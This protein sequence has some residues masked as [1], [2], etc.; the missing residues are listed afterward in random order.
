[1]RKK[2][3]V[4]IFAL[5][6]MIIIMAPAGIPTKTN[7]VASD[8]ASVP[9]QV[10]LGSVL[11]DEAHTANAS[12][13]WVPG[14]AS[15]FGWMLT[16]NGYSA[17]TNLDQEITPSLL[18]GYD[19]FVLFFPMVALSSNEVSTITS[20]V[21]NGG[22]VLLAGTQREINWGFDSS[23]LNPISEEYGVSFNNDV[24]EGDTDSLETH[25]I[26]G[27][28]SQIDLQNDAFGSCSLEVTSPA[29]SIITKDDADIAA[30]AESGSGRVVMVGSTIPFL[31]YRRENAGFGEDHFQFSLNVID[32]L[33]GNPQR[34]AN[35]PE[36]AHI[37]VGSG[38]ALSSAELEE[39][40]MSVGLYH[41]HTTHSDGQDTVEKMVEAGISSSLDFMLLTDHSHGTPVTIGGI[42]GSLAARELV[43]RY[44][45][46]INQF[47]GAELSG[48]K[49]TVGFP[50]TEN[51][52][53][54]NQQVAVD[55]IHAQGGLALFCH[56][57][58]AYNYAE[59]YEAMDALGYDGYE[60][61]N[62]GWMYGSGEG[63]LTHNFI[64]ASDGHRVSF[65][66]QVLNAVFVKDP[67]GPNGEMT[68][69]DFADAILDRRIVILDRV[70]NLIYGEK[71]WVDRF[72]ELR[73][74]AEITVEDAED[75]VEAE[76]ALGH[77]V[78][79]SEMY[80]GLAQ[81]ALD[82]WNPSR[83]IRMASDAASET[84]LGIS[85]DLTGPSV[86][87]P[88]TAFDIVLDVEN[89]NDFAISLNSSLYQITS[90]SV[91][92]INA[93]IDI[94]AESS[95]AATRTG[96]P[97]SEGIV[98]YWLN[99]PSFNTTEPLSPVLFTWNSAIDNVTATAVD[100]DSGYSADVRWHMDAGSRKLVSSVLIAYDDGETSE[101]V[102]MDPSWNWYEYRLGPYSTAT[103]VTVTVTVIDS[104]G[105][106]YEL[107]PRVITI[108]AT[109][110]PAPDLTLVIVGIGAV[111]VI[112]VVILFIKRRQV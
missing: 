70:N 96:T 61:D 76:Q 74:L 37:T 81:A 46:D 63:G 9:A 86:V 85:I 72:V 108:G 110:S 41:D 90:V 67:S 35:V 2:R 50:L 39:Y 34:E 47:I 91:T 42:T 44:G 102:E 5:F 23:R 33:A 68:Q 24:I 21:E 99:I 112:A 43:Q 73:N 53:T 66:G 103:N 111:A 98:S 1:M 30:Y 60:V 64:G 27:D 32:W 89:N 26:T 88:D 87:D 77:D 101:E 3:L 92:P 14:N 82:N 93:V 107:E 106:Q 83:A 79:L 6:V 54:S 51:I 65:V 22:G 15:L 56:P 18:S 58:I 55:E 94:A 31:S 17:T 97:D 84:A 49:H 45:L 25:P 7:D 8:V 95:G 10:P 4:P 57:T 62:G 36:I 59:V 20:F 29:E 40:E 52:F 69:E 12:S 13:L 78:S 16:E 11:F 38:P 28:V 100:G 104:D 80:L 48:V 19:V 105:V 109:G 75:V 71:V